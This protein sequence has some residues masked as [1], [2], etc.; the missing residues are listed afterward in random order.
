MCRLLITA[1]AALLIPVLAH[2]AEDPTNVVRTVLANDRVAEAKRLLAADY[3]RIVAELIKL[4]EIPAPTFKE[5]ERA[6][7]YAAMFAAQGAQDV[8]IDEAGNVLVFRPGTDPKA[9]IIVVSAHLDTVFLEGTQIKVRREGTR[10]HAPGIGDDARGLVNLLAYARVLDAAG[11]RTRHPIL[12]VGTVGEEGRG[13]TRGVR[14]LLTQGKYAGRVE[15]FFSIDD[16]DAARVTHVGIGVKRY[17]VHFEGPGGH[18]YTAFGIVNPIAAMASAITEIYQIQVPAGPKTSFAVTVIGGGTSVNVIPGATWFEIDLRSEDAA[19][20]ADLDTRVRNIIAAAV[21]SE[22][23]TRDIRAGDIRIK[24]EAIGDR[25]AGMTPRTGK[26]V[27][28]TTAAV[29]AMGFRPDFKAASTDA[30]FPMSI[31]IPAITIGAG[32]HGEREHSLD[33]WIDVSKPELVQGA[34]V[35]LIALLAAAELQ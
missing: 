20:L 4:T 9:G 6:A 15:S 21:S 31:G 22:N 32:G 10:L 18:S 11:V 16:D 7:A 2:A 26:F 13:N 8:S 35:G 1:S 19:A 30:N 12:F 27:M 33:E 24:F 14:Y 29:T 28:T 5:A 34:S 3:D 25:P 17:R 23:Q